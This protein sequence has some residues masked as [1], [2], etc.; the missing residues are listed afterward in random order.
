[1]IRRGY[2]LA[3]FVTRAVYFPD[4]GAHPIDDPVPVV[5]DFFDYIIV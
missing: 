4:V 1:M 3:A 2:L 5:D